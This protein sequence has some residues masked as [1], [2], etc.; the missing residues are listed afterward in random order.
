MRVWRHFFSHWQS[1]LGLLVVGSFLALAIFAPRIAPPSDPSNPSDYKVV[2]RKTD[3]VPH[4][5]NDQSPWG[6]AAGQID[7]YYSVVWGT[8][9]ALRFGL[10]VALSSAAIGVLAGAVSG[11]AGGRSNAVAMRVTD[12]FL[13][14]PV[15]AGVWLFQLVLFPPTADF[16]ST[17]LMMF[18][19]ESNITP[20]MVGLIAFSW[21]PYTR[22]IETNIT[23]LKTADFVLASQALGASRRRMIFRHL[24]P[25]SISPAIVLLARDIGGM[26]I[27]EAAFVFIGLSSGGPWAQLLV[28]NR[29]WIIGTGGNPLTYWWVYLPP[30]IA[31]IL[32]GIGWN[33][34][35]DGLNDALNPRDH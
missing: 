17:P 7:I 29:N 2:G 21:M 20:V 5:P 6:T 31:L 23:R 11:Y 25:N 1:W 8:R 35:G 12:A 26:V 13:A 14:F 33:L 18:F 32:F 24:I 22:L 9:A 30:T 27:L 10:I 3:R 34:L 19:A 15:I 16:K 28:D 4:P